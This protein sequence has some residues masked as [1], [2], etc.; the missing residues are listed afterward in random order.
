MGK[1][2]TKVLKDN[3]N[4]LWPSIPVKCGSFALEIFF[5]ATNESENMED[6]RLHT[7]MKR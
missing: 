5:H 4:L 6:L 3:E 2:L 7:F 1:G